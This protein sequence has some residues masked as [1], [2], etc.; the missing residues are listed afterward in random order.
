MTV[1]MRNHG[2][3]WIILVVVKLRMNVLHLVPF[4]MMD[5]AVPNLLVCMI[6]LLIAIQLKDAKV[7]AFTGMMAFVRLNLPVAQTTWQAA[8]LK[9]IVWLMVA[10]G[11]II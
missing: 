11:I 7:R 8:Q 10:N 5:S 1:V 9:P 4:G 3:G 6:H 2:V